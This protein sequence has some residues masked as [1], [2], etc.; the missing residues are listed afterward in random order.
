MDR[1]SINQLNSIR[2]TNQ[3]CDE[4]SGDTASIN[5]FAP[6]LQSSKNKVT[7]IDQFDQI[8]M[9]SSKGVT[10][11]TNGLRHTMT[12]IGFKCASATSAYA[13]SVK[14]NTLAVQVDYTIPKLDHLSKDVVD[15][16]CQTIREAADLNMPN[17]Q[18]FGINASDTSDLQSAINLYRISIQSPRQVIISVAE[19]NR[20]IKN[21]IREILDDL[22]KHLMDKMVNTL[23]QSKPSFVSKY[24]DARQ[25]IQLGA[26]SGILRGF[27][28]DPDKKPLADVIVSLRITSQTSVVAQTKSDAKGFFSI[29]NIKANNYDIELTLLGYDTILETDVHFAPGKNIKR[30]YI[31]KKAAAPPIPGDSQSA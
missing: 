30:K 26:S 20:Q 22:F 16:A 28:F 9:T 21:L 24:F 8:A 31:L 10:L 27:I 12:L 7:L 29:H 14:N 19:A 5:A 2:T 17:A 4:N 3:F 1:T 11:D 23:Q 13:Y 25:I 18:N 15:D 6:A